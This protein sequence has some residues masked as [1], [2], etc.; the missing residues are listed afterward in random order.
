MIDAFDFYEESVKSKGKASALGQ[1]YTPMPLCDLMAEINYQGGNEVTMIHDSAVGSGRTLL[2]YANVLNK[3]KSPEVAYYIANDI[4]EQSVKM[5]TLNFAINGMLGRVLCADGLLLHYY[6]GYEV[7]EVRYPMHTDMVAVRRLPAAQ[8][9]ES[10]EAKQ[11]ECNYWLQ[12]EPERREKLQALYQCRIGNPEPCIRMIP[13]TSGIEEQTF[14]TMHLLRLSDAMARFYGI[15]KPTPKPVEVKEEKKEE[16]K[17]IE[18]PI[19]KP[20]DTRQMVQR[21][22]FD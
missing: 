2:G 18:T 5:C 14:T 8:H 9:L 16:V 21:S 1:F 11:D 22:L 19:V 17:P 6:W 7:N 20:I 13:A 12:I 4:D 3:K 15:D 10:H